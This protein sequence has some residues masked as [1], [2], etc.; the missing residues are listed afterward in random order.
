LR[1]FGNDRGQKVPPRFHS[2]RRAHRND[3]GSASKS[4]GYEGS[5]VGLIPFG[6]GHGLLELDHPSHRVNGAGEL[7]Q[8][9]VTGRLHQPAAVTAERG[10]EMFR[11]LR[12]QPINGAI[13]IPAHEARVTGQTAPALPPAA[14]SRAPR[15]DAPLGST[16]QTPHPKLNRLRIRQQHPGLPVCHP[17][18]P[19]LVDKRPG[20]GIA[21]T[22]NVASFKIS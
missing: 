20:K 17:A 4:W 5:V 13:L 14:V 12:L 11:S 8:R 10:L 15:S 1:P 7:D 3:W 21:K 6:G 9:A 19:M 16:S 2:G 22:D 18:P